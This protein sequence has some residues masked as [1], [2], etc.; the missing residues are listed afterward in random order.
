MAALARK[1]AETV[2][3][4]LAPFAAFRRS[5]A[6]HSYM[7]PAEPTQQAYQQWLKDLGET[8]DADDAASMWLDV[9]DLAGWKHAPALVA[10]TAND[11][12]ELPLIEPMVAEVVLSE[13]LNPEKAQAWPAPKAAKKFR[14]WLIAGGR[15]GRHTA[16]ELSALYAEHCDEIGREGV[17]VNH[18]CKH[19][20]SLRGV[21]KAVKDKADQRGARRER[22]TVW[23]IINP[24]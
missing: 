24:E 4:V 20:I 19:L 8:L 11:Q 9:C 21:K 10:S 17:G 16:T 14:A 13:I 2:E 7:L 15:T 6:R 5:A 12:P 1:L 18:L 22:E 23:T 3:T